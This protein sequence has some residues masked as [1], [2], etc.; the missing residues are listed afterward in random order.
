MTEPQE[1]SN[2][3]ADSK[4]LQT[5][6]GPNVSLEQHAQIAAELAEAKQSQTDVLRAHGVTEPDWNNATLYWMDQ[7]GRDVQDNGADASLAM[8]YSDAFGRQQDSLGGKMAFT[9]EQWA[10]LQF[11]IE[12][13]GSLAV[14]LETRQ[15]SQPD[16]FRLVRIFSKR[17]AQDPETQVRFAARDKALRE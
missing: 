7:I 4:P 2:E 11:D 9:A 8:A 16:Y 13:E 17:V 14:P 1:P 15:L 10:E 6:G 3:A 5:N 12:R